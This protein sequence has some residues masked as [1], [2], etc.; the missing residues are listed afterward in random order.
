MSTILTEQ[1]VKST[2]DI[3]A[4]PGKWKKAIEFAKS[5][6]DDKLFWTNARQH[7]IELGGAMKFQKEDN[8]KRVF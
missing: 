6:N 2:L 5:K 7:F 4:Y 1:E 8:A 3:K